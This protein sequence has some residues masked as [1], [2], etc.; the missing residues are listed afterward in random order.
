ME[1]KII[2]AK[3]AE[4][5]NEL[6]GTWM[7]RVHGITE[8]TPEN[9][10]Q[11][12]KTY[13]DYYPYL[14]PYVAKEN[15]TNKKVLEIGL[16]YGTLGQLLASQGG[17]YYGLDIAQGPVE[18]MRYRLNQLGQPGE[19]RVKVGSALDIPYPEQYFDYVYT[20]GC[21]HHTG[22]LQKSIAEVHRVLKLGGK[23]IVMLYNYFS[24]R[25]LV[26][27]PLQRLRERGVFSASTFGERVRA[28]YDTNDQGEAAPHTDYTTP[29][30]V[31]RLFKNFS[32]VKVD[33]RNFETLS[34]FG[35]KIVVEREKLL[36]NVARV[37]GLDLYITATKKDG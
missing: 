31:R 3:N 32:R 36:D 15:L 21:L 9:L 14:A 11:F 1:Q 10:R 29:L 8:V 24:Y 35:N 25:Q 37:L 2:D 7:A 19:L 4:F 12:D 30:G 26:E 20:I 33:I 22:N 6:C 27:V 17:E 16:G 34:L 18:M 5:W 13:L 28:L 23:A